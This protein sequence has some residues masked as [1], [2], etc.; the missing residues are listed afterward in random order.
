MNTPAP[1]NPRALTDQPRRNTAPGAAAWV[2]LA[3]VAILG[4][5]FDLISKLLAFRHVADGPV[6]LRRADVIAAGPGGVQ[7]LLP[8]HEPV[9]VLPHVLEFRLVLNPGAVFG[10]GP[11]R[12]W[13]FILFTG[14]AIGMALWAFVRWT[15]R[16][17]RWAHVGIGLVL[18]GGFGNLYDRLV[19]GCVRD[20]VHPLPGVP[21]PFGLRWPGGATEVWP[22]VSNVADALLLIGIA[23]LMAHLWRTSP[24]PEPDKRPDRPA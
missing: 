3:L 23:L 18:A 11:G 4:T 15:T 10:I 1:S 16:H 20:F 12:R 5:A 7:G 21:L 9:T 17:D 14:L 19:I 8:P 6:T 22:W 13:F 2:T 24:Q